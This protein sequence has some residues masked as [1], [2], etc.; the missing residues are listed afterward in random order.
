MTHEKFSKLVTLLALVCT[1]GL[2]SALASQCLIIGDSQSAFSIEKNQKSPQ[3]TG[4]VPALKSGLEAMGHKAHFYA[5]KGSGAF[6]WIT[7]P[8]QNRNT[9]I[10]QS[11]DQNSEKIV[12]FQLKNETSKEV[13]LDTNSDKTFIDQIFDAHTGSDVDCFIIQLGDN[14]IFRDKAAFQMSELVKH[15][16]GQDNSPRLCAVIAP[17]FKEDSSKD[18]FPFITNQKKLS[19]I[20]QVRHHLQKNNLL[21]DCPV[22]STLT[23]KMES[24]LK[25]AE[26]RV[27]LDGL[28]YNSRG[29]KIWAE[30]ILQSRPFLG[31]R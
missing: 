7:S 21:E 16:L 8:K 15:V 13:S 4:L 17:T 25:E 1:F 27:T 26:K 18:E 29:G 22:I 10:G 9:L 5:L 3:S 2:E 12:P 31:N 11:K 23:P 30:N 14:D 20:T 24:E 6:D 28:F 19:Y